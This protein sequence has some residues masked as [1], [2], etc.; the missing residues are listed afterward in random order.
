MPN[1]PYPRGITRSPLTSERRDLRVTE[2]S[3]FVPLAARADVAALVSTWEFKRRAGFE[4]PADAPTSGAE[5]ILA[6]RLW[7]IRFAEPVRIVWADESGFG[8]ETMPGHPLYGEESFL[9]SEDGMFIARSISRPSSWWWRLAA[10]VLRMLQNQAYSRYIQV[11]D[12]ASSA[13]A[14]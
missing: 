8:Y 2:R 13:A 11:V 12:A 4:V 10:P 9:L 7:G 1:P 14:V 6:K 5:G 3:T